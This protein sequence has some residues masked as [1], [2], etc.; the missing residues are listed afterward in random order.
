[1][2]QKLLAF[3][4]TC[5]VIC[6]I[7]TAIRM[8]CAIASQ[9]ELLLV[10]S[11][12]NMTAGDCWAFAATESVEVINALAGNGAQTLSPQQVSLY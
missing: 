5:C 12:L 2:R 1:M 4:N 8:S 7:Y 10:F 11:S 3:Y 9:S 6:N